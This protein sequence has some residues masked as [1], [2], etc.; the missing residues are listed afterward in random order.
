MSHSDINKLF[1]KSSKTKNL[2]EDRT[3]LKN[4]ALMRHNLIIHGLSFHCVLSFLFFTDELVKAQTG[5]FYSFG[6]NSGD[7]V[8]PQID[9]GSSPVVSLAVSFPFFGQIYRQLYVN[10]NG[11]ITFD[12]PSSTYVPFRFPA[13]S[14]IDIIAPFWT[15][16][17]NRNNGIISYRQITFGSVLQQA[18]RDINQ[19]FPQIQFTA[20]WVFIAT[21]DRV[22]YYPTSGTETTFQ[23][24]LISGGT[25][26]FVLMNYGIIAATG[27]G[28][29]AGYDTRTSDHHFLI[30]GSFESN[31]TNLMHT[32]NVNV[33]GRWAF[34]TD[35]GN[36]G[37]MFN[38][39]PV[40]VGDSFWSDSTCQSKCT[41]VSSGNLRCQSQPCG[42][43]QVCQVSTFQY[44]CQTV[45]R[46]T[47]TI[48]GD[49]HYYTF[50]GRLFHFQGTCTYVLSQ[51]C[52]SRA[53]GLAPYRVEGKNEN[54]GSTVVA[55]TKLVRII[56]YGEEIELVKGNTAQAKV[57]GSFA[58]AP[59]SLHNGTVRI[60]QT[61]FSL[62]VST[63]FGLTVAYDGY[64]YVTISVPYDYLN[65]T[66]GLCGT[67][68]NNPADDF[69]SS[70]GSVLSSDVNFANSW[71]VY[72]D[73]EPG[74]QPPCVGASCAAC[75]PQQRTLFSS[76]SHCGIL[77]NPVGAFNVCHSRLPPS[78]FVESCV[79]DLCVGRGYQPILCQALNVYATQCQQEGLHPGQWRR[80]GFCEIT[81]PANSHFEPQG[82]GCPA[83]CADP[84]APSHCP[85]PSQESCICD[86]GFVLSAGTCV[87][88]AQCGCTFEGRYYSFGQTA[89]LGA[90]CG[91]R[92]TCQNGQ[93][94]C[95]AHACGPQEACRIENGER[96]CY[97]LSYNMCWVEGARRY[98]TFDGLTFE[99][100]GA[101]SLTLSKVMGQSSLRR[102][103]VTAK[104][105]PR[106]TPGVDFARILRFETSGVEI[107]IEMGPNPIVQV[108]EQNTSLPFRR[109]A[110]G[111]QV[112]LASLSRVVVQ[113]DFGVRMEADW[114][115]LVR[116]TVPSTYN[117]TLGGLCGNDN[118]YVGDE[119]WTPDGSFENDSQSFGDSWRDGSLSAFCVE[120][121]PS[122]S[123]RSGGNSSQY[124]SGQFCGIMALPQGPFGQ[125]QGRFNP[126]ERIDNC[127][128]DMYR[129][130]GAS[131][132]LCEALRNYALLCQQNGIA[133]SHW[134]NLT[135]C[136]INCP[137]HSHYEL[138][139]TSCPA[140]CPSLS[141]PFTCQGTCQEGCQCDNG[142][143]LSNGQCVSPIDCGCQ[144]QGRYYRGGQSF[145]DGDGCHNFCQ[146][147]GTTGNVQ[148]S[149]SSCGELESCRIVGDDYGCHPKP[150]G[151]CVA[152][153][154][155][156]YLTF[157]GRAFD[158]QGTC[159]YVLA[160]LCNSSTGL[161]NFQIEAR[162]ERWQ[163]LSVSVTSDVF[164]HVY[165]NV[166]HISRG[167]SGTVEVDDVTKNLPILL[168]RGQVSVY[169]SGIY[170]F[171]S[172]DFG[173]T[174]SYD[175]N[176]VVSITL[177]PRF[178][179]RTCGLCGNF[180]G[181]PADDFVTRSGALAP[182]PFDF[183]SS[184]KTANN[185][186]CSDG[187]GNSCPACPD[188][189][190]ARSHCE[191]IQ[192][193]NGPLAFC[194]S[195]VSPNTYF[196]DCVFDV[197]LSG[198]RNDVLCRAVQAYVGACQAANVRALPWRQGTPC[199]ISCPAHSHYEM[200]GT[201][202]GQTCA[203]T[204]D[205]HCD[206]TC[207]EG[208]FCDQGFF[209]SGDRCVPV[210]ECGCQ[211]DGFYYNVGETFWTPGC[212]QRC[213]CHAHQDLRCVAAGCTPRQ[214]C[215]IRRG[216]LGCF[217]LLSTCTVTGDP[218]YFTFDGAV[219]HFQGTCSYEI[220]R[221]CGN[222]TS[223]DSAFR[224]VAKN[225][226]HGSTLV[227][228]VSAVDIW[229]SEGGQQTH[230]SIGT[231]RSVQVN[232]RAI[233]IPSAIG[234][235][236]QVSWDR[237]FVVVNASNDLE[238]H[239]NGRSTL[240]V[241]LGQSH[242]SS[243][244][245][246][247]GNFNGDPADDKDLPNGLPAGSDEEFGNGW[248]SDTSSP[249]CG[250]R[251]RSGA[252]GCPF[253]QEYTELCS[254]ISN[255]TGPFAECHIHIDPEPYVSACVYDL[256]LYTPVNGIF[257]SA[258]S[259]YEAAC[260]IL[261]LDIP[262]WRP[263][264]Q[265]SLTDPCEQLHCTDQEWCGE[266][267]GVYGC[268]CNEDHERPNANN[269]D[270]QETCFSSSGIMSLSRCLLFEE[271][272][273]PH[274]LHLNDPNCTGT[275]IN[276][277]VEFLFD[278]DNHT[279]G[280]SLTTNGTHFIY[281]NSIHGAIDSSGGV[282]S[283]TKHI[284]LKFSCVYLLSETMSMPIGI[285]PLESIVRKNLPSGIGTYQVRLVPY[286]DSQ[287][288]HPFTGS[289][290]D[291]EL[292]Q[293][294]YIG[295]FV[296]GVDDRQFSSVLESCWAT[297]VNDP[298]Y[299]IRWNLITHEC[300]SSNDQT[301]EIIQNG[302]STTS[303]F[304]FQMFEFIGNTSM[305]FLHCQV[306]LCILAGNDC[307]AHCYPGYHRRVA[308]DVNFHDG[309]SISM[310]PLT[311]SQRSEFRKVRSVTDGS[312][313]VCPSLL[314]LLCFIG[315]MLMG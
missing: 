81:C 227:S 61:G 313:A 291:L 104:K 86:T 178:R 167:W 62:A 266:K 7:A 126:S 238:V 18:T 46:R 272:F 48:A 74:C 101:C 213:M 161:P 23:V 87:P 244:C 134:R 285:H 22:A 111:V 58:T 15:D 50:D 66:C 143:I 194:H 164:V 207:S 243:V 37:C 109:E 288:S 295:V 276:G 250:A 33:L 204:I 190:V 69:L 223:G 211:Y 210:E 153:G 189:R 177:P 235:V 245:G 196:N 275:V 158:F 148:C 156:H 70:S 53:Q 230:I 90:D 205:A 265:C 30:P 264:V 222:V 208:C 152:A 71:Q 89:L 128:R 63:D 312:S 234:S 54:R 24:V 19:Y 314:L 166:V 231:S 49:P 251:V 36:T 306:K 21:W 34:H 135:N 99:Y 179:G 82:T 170:T 252:Q 123:P 256:C 248:I 236:A 112:Y 93:M 199:A 116:L 298:F 187:C 228:F 261:G 44:S 113:T 224:V 59:F 136:Q 206:Q 280:T 193:S 262:E 241:R 6:I 40:Q 52:G 16:L 232:N 172:V 4:P 183:G 88:A 10:N 299:S 209:R 279:C 144:Y 124:L 26:S 2:T 254:I 133:I 259:S 92:C 137:P 118:G 131:E 97:P 45:Q 149:P 212:S 154:D 98:R 271:G 103:L 258:V 165:G 83:T 191:V 219:A 150:H 233:S 300:P 76:I 309:T 301:V 162:N 130:G 257:C 221:T 225:R 171:V 308:R 176:S 260:N 67:F 315:T 32:S 107:S 185:R 201:E 188:D 5:Q 287:F 42:F 43:D 226:H 284:D 269:Y 169:Q 192:A 141:F 181:Q 237:D 200:C 218:H 127:A 100:P 198:N 180:N 84:Q 96:G 28:V 268:F 297:P 57:N 311:W 78:S 292:N 119:F 9:D 73:S 72:S 80:Q 151:T 253:Q 203:G 38:G 246:M 302:V 168:Q 29:E 146:C 202:C 12:S 283:R 273:P 129:Q 91:R 217:D 77:E 95:Q 195:T 263:S 1:S 85:L 132:V 282:I 229:L 267:D 277:R 55:W 106:G 249:G 125:C 286:Q 41:C 274:I 255:T 155:P 79:Y 220:S 293:R 27:R 214:E 247:C 186:S 296:S 163:G 304:S 139:E 281:N 242:R 94:S 102:F 147:N 114:P 174:V 110:E 65:A 278:N 121:L 173:L 56:V 294:V 25:Y 307:S 68:N 75:Q 13:R 140:A 35:S 122:T 305:I 216:Q 303:R 51:T 39:N 14:G 64:S 290:V 159:D 120:N 105:V 157:D 47:C 3:G 31:I 240:F 20:R 184:W 60:Y 142:F 175:G 115:H 145:W 289:Q 270:A 108:G 17:D 138:C 215:T 8:S 197:C 239:F 117:G 310:G 11:F 182:T 160:T